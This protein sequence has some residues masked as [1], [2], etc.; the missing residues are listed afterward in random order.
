MMP[1]GNRLEDTLDKAHF[2][3]SE[4][5][6]NADMKVI[7]EVIND[8]EV[9]DVET[10]VTG[11]NCSR[12]SQRN[13]WSAS[14]SNTAYGSTDRERVGASAYDTMCPSQ[15]QA[16]ACRGCHHFFIEFMLN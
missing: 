14:E 1:M 2:D 12:P 7:N 3:Y 9:I 16:H 6:F 13:N 11:P 10:T 4:A 8:A 5:D 15:C